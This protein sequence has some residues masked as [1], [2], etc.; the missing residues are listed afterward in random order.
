MNELLILIGFGIVFL[1]GVA[2]LDKFTKGKEGDDERGK[3]I[4]YKTQSFL[5]QFTLCGVL[6]LLM[7]ELSGVLTAQ[8]FRNGIVY[9]ILS[10]FLV[11]SIYFFWRKERG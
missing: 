8:Q 7:L 11:G 2:L 3:L 6:L 5:F 10:C 4:Q 9:L 1:A